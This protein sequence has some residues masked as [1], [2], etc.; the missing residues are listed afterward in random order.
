MRPQFT[1]RA[2]LVAMLVVAA[3][4]GGIMLERRRQRRADEAAAL[5]AITKSLPPFLPT[6]TAGVR[7]VRQADGALAREVTDSSGAVTLTPIESI[8]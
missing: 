7:I 3:F 1:L 5:D 6:G 2:L 8:K 4:F